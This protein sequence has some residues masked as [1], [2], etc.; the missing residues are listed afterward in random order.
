VKPGRIDL[1]VHTSASDGIMSP[2]EV[3]WQAAERGV[4]LLGITDHDTTEGLAEA[5]EAAAAAGVVLVPG[6]ELSADSESHDIHILGYFVNPRDGGLQAALAELRRGR[7]RRNQRIMERLRSVGAPVSPERVQEI[8]GAGTV[9]RP[10]IALALLEAGHVGSQGE[11]FGRYLAR[12]KPAFVARERLSPAEA[13]ATIRSSGGLA[14]LAHPGKIGSWWV[15]EEVLA[16]GVDGIEVFHS[17][18]TARDAER[19]LALAQERSLLVTG[20]TD[21]HGPHS[22]RP[23][24]VGDAAVPRSVGEELLSRAPE[25]WQDSDRRR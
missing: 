14:V 12:G 24:A 1:H 6:V 10:H 21:S 8:A 4:F 22:E 25:W 18:H 23:L 13:C 17:D 15:I 3:V 19:L 9:G 5:G 2:S 20:G 7:N 11:A 16:S